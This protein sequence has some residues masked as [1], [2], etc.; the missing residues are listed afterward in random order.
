VKTYRGSGGITP[1]NRNLGTRWRWMV[2]ITPRPLYRREITR[3]P[4]RMRLSMQRNWSGSRFHLLV[5]YSSAG[6][7][8]AHEYGALCCWQSISWA[9]CCWQ[10]ISW[11]FE[12]KPSTVPLCPPQFPHGQ[13]RD[14]TRASAVRGLRLPD[15]VCV[16]SSGSF[17]VRISAIEA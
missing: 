2:D 5:L 13:A 6:R 15:L 17:T 12:E 9:L 8:V 3:N 14:W 16:Q 7:W 11:A 4:M 1:L 10:S